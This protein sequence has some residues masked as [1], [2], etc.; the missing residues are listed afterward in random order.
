M[1]IVVPI[2]KVLEEAKGIKSIILP[3]NLEAKPGQFAMLWI[4][5]VDAKPIAVSYQD[6][7]SC[8][9]TI[10]A[11]GPWSEKICKMKQGELIGILGPYGSSFNLEGGSILMMGGG[12]GTATLMLL[13]EHASKQKKKITMIIGARSKDYVVFEQRAKKLGIKTIVTTDDGSYG[14][15]GFNTVVLERLLKKE[16]FD[17]AFICG[18]EL[19]ERKAAEICLAN[20][21][22]CELSVERYMKCGFGICGACCMDGSGKR[23]CV[24][25]TVFS[26]EDALAMK[27]FGRYHRDG[28]ATKHSFGAKNE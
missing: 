15:K 19:M 27:E 24:E 12:Y 8:G 11:V 18:P 1:P 7:K 21:V 9:F 2:L 13:A 20:K 14:E 3:Y 5:G 6:G 22:K 28:S 4:P 10:S 17:K 23:V 16:K 26:G 25:G